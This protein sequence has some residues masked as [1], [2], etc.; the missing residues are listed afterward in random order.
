M[1]KKNKHKA[2]LNSAVDKT[3][4]DFYRLCAFFQCAFFEKKA[5]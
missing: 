2:K 4:M 5:Y 1:T 3:V